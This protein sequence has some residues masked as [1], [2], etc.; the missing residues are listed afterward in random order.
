MARLNPA[1]LTAMPA[2]ASRGARIGWAHLN[3]AGALRVT[4]ASGPDGFGRVA[5]AGAAAVVSMVGRCALP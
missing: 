2:A 1:G 4:A 3:A 5:A